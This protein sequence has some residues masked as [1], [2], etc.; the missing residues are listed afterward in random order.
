LSTVAI[1]LIALAALLIV[2]LVGG[3]LAS[4]RRIDDP[5]LDQR[6]VAADRALEHARAADRGWERSLLERAA[7]DALAAERPGSAWEDVALVLV[8]DRPGVEDDRCHV[9]A[10]GP[11]GQA[12][13]ILARRADG[14]WF[15]E[16]VG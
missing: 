10:T 15:A 12:R 8:D 5:A 7:L 3:Y 2:L 16:Q 1:V 11:A 6:I 9:I 14:E 4:R 13:V